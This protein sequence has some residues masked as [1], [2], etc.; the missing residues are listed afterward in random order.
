[1]NQDELKQTVAMAV[2]DYIEDNT[3]VGVGSGTTVKYFIEALSKI[4]NRIDGAVASSAQ[5]AALLKAKGIPL[6]E[7]NN[8]SEIPL[9]IDSADAFTPHR[10]LVK[11]GGGALTREKIIAS[12]S[13]TF[14]CIVDESKKV[15]V[16]GEFP[17]AVEV[18]PMARSF[19]AREIVKLEGDPVYRENFITDNG[20]I[21]LDVYNWN[22]MEPIKLE[23]HLNNIPG[24]VC[25]GIF[26]DRPADQLLIGTQTGMVV[27]GSGPIDLGS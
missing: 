3:V 9:Y 8:V 23:H 19:V 2:L 22:I 15:N 25:N 14:V 6:L 20:N 24:I 7:L 10:Q 18:I 17:V 13:K 21:I 11:G 16:L 5:T 1:M 26:A 4:K 12:A 27:L